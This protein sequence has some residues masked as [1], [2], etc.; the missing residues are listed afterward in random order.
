MGT[1]INPQGWAPRTV[2]DRV[3]DK[4]R[5]LL[6]CCA[7]RRCVITQETMVEF[8]E[9][10]IKVARRE[11]AFV[12]Y[13]IE[14]YEGLAT[15]S[16]LDASRGLLGLAYPA[17]LESTLLDLVEDLRVQGIVKEVHSS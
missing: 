12:H 7:R 9:M 8:R 15:V 3:H 2:T 6:E 14:A 5:L 11:I 16:T 17:S 10:S 4:N 13:V 1:G